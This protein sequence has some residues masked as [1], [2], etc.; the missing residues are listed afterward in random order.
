MLIKLFPICNGVRQGGILSPKLFTLYVNQLNKKLI[1]C[2]AG[3]YVNSMCINYV[4]YAE[5]Q[6]IY[7][8]LLAPTASAM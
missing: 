1:A 5:L 2:N 4:M 3:C 7:L 6:M 8:C